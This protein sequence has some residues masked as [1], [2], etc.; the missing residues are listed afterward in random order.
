MKE[1]FILLRVAATVPILLILF[2]NCSFIHTGRIGYEVKA[3]DAVRNLNP[4]VSDENFDAIVKGNS[5]FAFE[6][7]QKLKDSEGNLF[8]SPY[9]LSVALGMTW[10]GARGET[11][12]QMHE[13]MHFIMPQEV[14]HNALNK[15]DL[16][17]SN[18]Q[19]VTLNIA[20][21]I[22]C[23]KDEKFMPDF[24]NIITT[25]Y[26]SGIHA[27]DFVKYKEESRKE[28]NKWV[29]EKTN[30]KIIEFLPPESVDDLTVMVLI[31]AI[32]FLGEWEYKFEVENTE[33]G[34]FILLDGSS[35]KVPYM[36]QAVKI[37]MYWDPQDGY[38]AIQLPYKEGN[39]AMV[40]L[41]PIPNKF[42]EFEDNLSMEKLNEITSKFYIPHGVSLILPKV[43]LAASLR[44]SD[45]LKRMGMLNAFETTA[46]FSGMNG[47]G[48]IWID[49]VYHKAFVSIDEAGTE[50][51]AASG[52]AMTRGGGNG[53]FWAT[54]PFIF[55][56]MDIESKSL[57]F[58]GRVLNPLKT[59]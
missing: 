42:Q 44:L 6:L 58:M 51:A 40:I 24:L 54:S 26:N 27:A 30:S 56:I 47:S 49:E 38:S 25:N 8:F 55:V 52:V 3:I 5:E 2:T 57:I 36:R 4:E 20:N 12:K 9:S 16:A 15:L 48:G 28:I 1:A 33:I 53:Y 23:Q 50:A 59:E 43:K 41:L 19:D 11:E 46:D 37:P 10:A 34:D 45:V 14:T 22:W 17:L 39:I 21:S 31:N 32:Y 13:V 29:E 35:V 18:R 7:Y